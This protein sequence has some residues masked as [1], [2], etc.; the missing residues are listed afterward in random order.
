MGEVIG[1]ALANAI[2]LVDGLVV[3]GGGLSGA[4]KLFLPAIVREMNGTLRSLSGGTVPRMET[5][6]FNLKTTLSATCSS[7][8]EPKTITIPG[9]YR[10]LSYDPLKR[11]GVGLSRL[12]TSKAIAVGAYAFALNALDKG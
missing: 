9:T 7:R 6:A 4:A 8:G 1:D 2:T 3:V 10:K 5:K 11:V 12:G